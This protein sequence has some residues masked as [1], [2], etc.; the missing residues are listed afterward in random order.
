MKGSI[1]SDQTCPVC[2][3]RFKS[4]E[5][6]GLFCPEHPHQCPTSFVVRYRKIT[7][8]FNTYPAAHQF[9]T[10]LR[11]QDGSGQFDARDYQ[12]KGK[13]LAFDKLANEWLNLK[14]TQIKPASMRS[15]RSA[16]QKAQCAWGNL[17]IKALKYGH[18]ED[19]FQTYPGA[20]KSKFNALTILKQFWQWAI[21][22]YDIPAIT[23]WPKIGYVQMPIATPLI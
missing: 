2:G 16:I 4:Q 3:S 15:L 12:T 21:D 8:R 20:P 22:R 18:I 5:P 17:N 23:K 14:A 19:F 10:G 7:K 6:K 13:P 11:F 1:H 9:L